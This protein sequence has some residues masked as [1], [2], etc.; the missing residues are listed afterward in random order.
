MVKVSKTTKAIA[1]LRSDRLSQDYGLP[2]EWY[3]NAA[4]VGH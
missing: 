1:T 2:Q 4:I 3:R